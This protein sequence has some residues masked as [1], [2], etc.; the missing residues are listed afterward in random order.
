MVNS[1]AKLM[2]NSDGK[3]IGISDLK[4]HFRAVKH[5]VETIKMVTENPPAI[6]TE[7]ITHSLGF[8]SPFNDDSFTPA[9]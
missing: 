6:L 5:A 4:S 7:R 9:A 8:G 2:K 3:Y 1:S